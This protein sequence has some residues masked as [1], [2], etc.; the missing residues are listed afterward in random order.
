[1]KSILEEIYYGNWR[2]DESIK[3]TDHRSRQ[4]IQKISDSMTEYNKNLSKHDFE[5]LEKLLDCVGELNSM[6]A[7]A[8]FANGYRTGA[9]MMIEV[10]S[11]EKESTDE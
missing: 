5:Q 7:A 11:G 10:F 8:A 2:P 9:L 6:H 1:M 4:I 3:S